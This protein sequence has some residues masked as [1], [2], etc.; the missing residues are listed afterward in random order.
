[1]RRNGWRGI[2]HFDG[3]FLFADVTIH[4]IRSRKAFSSLFADRA[5]IGHDAVTAFEAVPG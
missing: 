5:L 1:L 3:R 4:Q 2:S